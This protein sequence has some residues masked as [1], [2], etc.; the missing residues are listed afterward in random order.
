MFPSIANRWHSE[1]VEIAEF[2]LIHS[3]DSTRVLVKDLT[4]LESLYEDVKQVFSLWCNC[5]SKN[6]A[7]FV[8]NH[9]QLS[10]PYTCK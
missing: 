6:G 8:S 7:S 1:I 4:V 2:V 5:E 9:L 3:E 10:D